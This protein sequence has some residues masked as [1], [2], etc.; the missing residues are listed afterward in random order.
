MFLITSLSPWL[1]PVSRDKDTARRE[2]ILNIVLFSS[3]LLTFIALVATIRSDFFLREHRHGDSSWMIFGILS[4]YLFFFWLSKKGHSYFVSFVL[5]GIYYLLVSNSIL[6]WGIDMPV[7]LL[8]YALLI[9]MAGILVDSKF[10]L[11]LMVLICGTLVVFRY[12]NL[13]GIIVF[14]QTWKTEPLLGVDVLIFSIIFMIIAAISWLF[15][16]EGEKALS[17][18]RLSEIALQKERDSLAIKVEKKTQELRIQQAEKMA[19]L[20]RFAEYGKLASGFLHD[21]SNSVNLVSANLRQIEKAPHMANVNAMIARAQVGTRRLE[22]FIQASRKQV[23]NQ[24]YFEYF[25]LTTEI[26]QVIQ[27]VSYKAKKAQVSIVFQPPTDVRTYGNSIKFHQLV[28]NLVS[29]AIDSYDRSRK[30]NK[31]VTIT[32]EM[33]GKTIRLAIADAGSGISPE[34]LKSIFNPFFTTKG[35]KKGTGIGLSISHDIV[36][37]DFKGKIFAESELGRGTTFVVEFPQRTN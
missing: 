30:Q 31:T 9:V 10:S 24:D 15:N 4:V 33:K 36:I 2:H 19:Q 18:A 28:G 3:V 6:I 17:R 5:V 29:N 27:I 23:N 8:M 26:N 16:R 32:V 21:I 1:K 7:G 25:S 13:I 20:Y 14:D 11:F 37:R 34:N 35:F 22:S 12:L